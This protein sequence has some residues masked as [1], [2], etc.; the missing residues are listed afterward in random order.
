MIAAL[1][2]CSGGLFTTVD[3]GA[4]TELRLR[5]ATGQSLAADFAT[6][7]YARLESK[8]RHFDLKVDTRR[9]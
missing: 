1:A 7:P 4:R 3:L 9:A 5:D 2:L 8:S 6:F